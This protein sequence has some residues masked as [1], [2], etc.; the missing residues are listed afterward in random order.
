M[1]GRYCLTAQLSAVFTAL[2]ITCGLTL[3]LRAADPHR[4]FSGKWV[5]DTTASD[6]ASLG[7]VENNLTVSQ[8]DAGILCST[9]TAEWSYA[10]DGSETRKQIGEESRSSVAKWEGAALLIN[11]QVTG[12]PHYTVMDRWELSRSHNTL[13][14]TRQVVRADSEAEGTLVFRR[15]GAQVTASPPAPPA[16]LP[17]GGAPAGE[18]PP[19]AGWRATEAGGGGSQP[20]LATRPAAGVPPDITIPTGTRVL[21]ALIGEVNT[22]HAKEGDRVYLRTAT[23]V[24]AGGRLV[25]PRGSDVEGT[26]TKAKAAGKVVGK[27]ELYI[28]FDSLIL[29]NGVSRDFHARPPGE[30]G[31]VEGNGKS[32]DGRTVIEGAGAG[33]AIGAITHGLPGAAVGGV[34]G[35]LAGVLLSRNQDVVLRSGAHIEMVLDRDLVFHPEEL[36]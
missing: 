10:L 2:L 25:I 30:E 21:L 5:L 3:P 17:A 29:P 4:D 14:I 16:A 24:A 23:P 34:G 6:V 18:A 13:T 11:T 1:R 20:G 26:I 32:A 22:K 15:E 28:R 12:T 19:A 9:K 31:K 33:G 36:P 8:G 35:A 27:G 7:P